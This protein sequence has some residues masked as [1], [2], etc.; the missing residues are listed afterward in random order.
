V[1]NSLGRLKPRAIA[2]ARANSAA[3][4]IEAEQ[5][6]A[7]AHSKASIVAGVPPK[8]QASAAVP[9]AA[10]VAVDP[11]VVVEV[12]EDADNHDWKNGILEDWKNGKIGET[13]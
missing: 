11:V 5:V 8:A 13:E 1:A 10:A 2:A 12:A 4:G 6:A 9:A 7:A 3:V